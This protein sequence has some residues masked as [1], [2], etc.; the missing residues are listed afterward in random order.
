MNTLNQVALLVDIPALGLIRGHVGVI[1][2]VLPDSS[3]EVEFY[4]KSGE[5]YQT[6]IIYQNQLMLLHF[7]R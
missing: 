4:D 1:A 6:G 7:N 3:Y 2:E 5:M